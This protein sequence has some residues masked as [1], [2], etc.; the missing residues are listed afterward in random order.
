MKIMMKPE[1]IKRTETM[2]TATIPLDVK[3]RLIEAATELMAERE[4]VPLSARD[5]ELWMAKN[6]EVIGQRAIDLQLDMF[7]K[8]K[9]RQ[10]KIDSIISKAVYREIRD[11]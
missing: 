3:A 2:S 6:A 11:R 9:A 1:T 8:Y 10:C 5:L 4:F 7:V